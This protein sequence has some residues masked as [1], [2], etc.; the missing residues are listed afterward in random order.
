MLRLRLLPLP[1]AMSPLTLTV[2]VKV[3]SQGVEVGRLPAILPVISNG[4]VMEALLM[5][6]SLLRA[7]GTEMVSP[8]LVELWWRTEVLVLLSKMIRWPLEPAMS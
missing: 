6:K 5:S 8:A 2:P 7:K 3:I 4:F 1:G